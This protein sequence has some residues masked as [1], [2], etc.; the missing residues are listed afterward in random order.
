VERDAVDPTLGNASRSHS[1]FESVISSGSTH[2][3]YTRL[4]AMLFNTTKI[5]DILFKPPLTIDDDVRKI[6][7]LGTPALASL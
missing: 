1:C 7:F 5:V 3:T 4:N 2:A 6:G